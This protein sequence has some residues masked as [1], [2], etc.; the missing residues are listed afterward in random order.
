MQLTK[1][2]IKNIIIFIVL[3]ITFL[4]FDFVFLLFNID[5]NEISLTDELLMIFT[6]YF[7]F[8]TFFVYYYYDYF[9]D[10]WKDF[11]KNIKKYLGIS[12][13]YWITGFIIMYFANSIIANYISGVGENE[14]YVQNLISTTPYISLIL[15]TFFAPFI[16]E[17]IFRKS[18]QDC[19][20]NPLFYMITSGFLF[21]FIH[22]LGA[23]DPYEY[24]LIISY[25]AMGFFFAKIVHETDNIFCSIMVHAFHNFALTLLSILV[26]L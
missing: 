13:K 15:T 3:L 18:L 23:A 19:F 10:K 8:I 2:K 9:K 22:V 21:G 14:E 12:F 24:L 7:C 25:G 5:F 26:I 1:L 20:N 6:K 16:E 17:M 11:K 4:L